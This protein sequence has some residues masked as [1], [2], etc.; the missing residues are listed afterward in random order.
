MKFFRNI[1]LAF[2]LS[3]LVSAPLVV[4][5]IGEHPGGSGFW[6]DLSIALGYAGM[7]MVALNLY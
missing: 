6:L 1:I 2:R 7:A 4:L 5:L 3:T